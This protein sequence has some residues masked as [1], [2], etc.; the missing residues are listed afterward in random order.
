LAQTSIK[1]PV[2]LIT[3]S[4]SPLLIFSSAIFP[5]A[6][7]NLSAN[8][9]EAEEQDSPLLTGEAK[10]SLSS[11]FLKAAVHILKDG[12]RLITTCVALL[13]NVEY[14]LIVPLLN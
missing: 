5:I 11:L 2:V 4:A 3:S 12:G 7:Y 9:N 13:T 8:S 10:R 14:C 6:S 1:F